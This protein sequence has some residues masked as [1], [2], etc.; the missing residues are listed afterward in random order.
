MLHNE[1]FVEL[2]D[3]QQ[4]LVAGGFGGDFG[5]SATYFKQD[6]N[7]FKTVSASNAHG[8]V[9]GGEAMELDTKTFGVN[10]IYL[11]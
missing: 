3:D 9:A 6:I 2:S 7:L 10:A 1:L 4:E 8:S 11:S 5:L